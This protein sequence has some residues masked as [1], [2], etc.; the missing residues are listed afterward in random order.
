[1]LFENSFFFLPFSLDTNLRVIQ[2][3]KLKKTVGQDDTKKEKD[4]GSNYFFTHAKKANSCSLILFFFLLCFFKFVNTDEEESMEGEYEIAKK[5][6]NL[7]ELADKAVEAYRR[8]DESGAK[9]SDESKEA[10]KESKLAEKEQDEEESSWAEYVEVLCKHQLGE[11][12]LF[13]DSTGTYH[14]HWKY[15][16]SF[17]VVGL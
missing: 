1:M 2:F 5:V 9:S 16:F 4:K 12:S 13:N 6:L 15:L 17:V 10:E 8:K 14:S 3:E 7:G 11:R